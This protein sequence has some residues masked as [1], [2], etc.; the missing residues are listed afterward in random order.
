MSHAL[1]G[2]RADAS[3]PFKPYTAYKDSQVEFLGAI[4]E[5]WVAKRLKFVAGKAIKNGIGEAGAY[6]NPEWPRYVRITDVAGSRE[7]REDTFKS[8]PPDLAREA[9]F[10][11]GDLLLAAVGATFGKSYLH[12]KDIGLVCF[13]GYMV[14]FTPGPDILPTFAGYWTESASYWALVQSRVVQATIQ[15]FSAAK[16]RELSVPLP[17]V[18]EQR[19]IAAFLDRETGKIDALIAKKQRLIDLLQE[20]RTALITHAVTKGLDPSVRMKE[21][22]VEWL[23][24]VPEHWGVRRLKYSLR[25]PLAYGVLKP[26]RHEGDDGVRLVR[27]LDV[28]SGSVCAA[29]LEQVSPEQDAEFRRTKLRAG[30]LVISVVGTIGRCFVVTDEL[31][32]ANLSRALARIQLAKAVQARFLEYYILSSAFGAFS[33]LVPGGTAQRVLNLGDLGEFVVPI[34]S[35]E[36]QRT[37]ITVLDE[38]TAQL[39][40]LTARVREA[41]DRLKEFRSALISAAVTGKIDVREEV[42]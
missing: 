10:H 41:A 14:R 29:N 9:P 12:L 17:S 31:A 25:A 5:H 26:D 30:D 3:R 11:V 42:A 22:G 13:A 32:G 1:G 33:D 18:P 15:N 4:P 20:K 39:D 19:A 8:L 2:R 37:I 23:G 27:I 35:G 36:E 6:D 7:L 34:P 16:Y 24:E 40:C 38:E 28:E 21:S